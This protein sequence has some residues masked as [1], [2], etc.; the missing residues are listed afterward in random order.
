LTGNVGERGLRDE[1]R[2]AVAAGGR[3]VVVNLQDASAIDSSGVSDLASSHMLLTGTGGSLKICCLSRKLK[4]V[5]AVTRLDTVFQVF[6][7]EADALASA[8]AP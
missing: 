7:T 8:Q 4:D 3:A 2:A 1:I 6:D 5:F